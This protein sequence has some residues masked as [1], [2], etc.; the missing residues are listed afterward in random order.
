MSSREHF[1][2]ELSTLLTMAGAAIGLGNVWRFPYMMGSYGG[3][4][5]LLVFLF[6]TVFFAIPAV[7]GEWAL[8]RHTRHGPI[9][10]F[11]AALGPK[12]GRV[13]GYSLV[14]TVIIA[15][16]YYLVVIGNIFY[17]AYFAITQGFDSQSIPVFQQ[18]LSNGSLQYGV[19]C[20]LLLAAIFTVY[21]GLRNGIEV[22]SKLFVPFFFLTMLYLIFAA[23]QLP[24]ASEQMLVFLTP[25]FGQINSEVIFT[26]MG[27]AFF[28]M[29]LG[30]T[31]ILIYGSYMNASSSLPKQALFTAFSDTSAAL[32]AGM[33]IFPVCL[34]L[35]FKLDT[36]PNLIFVTMPALFE[37]MPGGQILG[38]FF[39]LA[40]SM[41]A[42]L[43]AIAALE[44]IVGGLSDSGDI[45]LSRKKIV[46]IIGIIE[47]L[48]MVGP[49][50]RPE[51][52]GTLDLIFGSG[53]QVLGSCLALIA[54]TFGFKKSIT[55]KQVFG[56]EKGL[57]PRIYF[58]WIHWVVPC[59]L[60]LVLISFIFDAIKGV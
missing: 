11:S 46:I 59:V 8:G 20:I 48:L 52:I 1:S 18:N 53:T 10:A 55:L 43:S 33:F 7:M 5:F 58:F 29:G 39:L 49:A 44:V 25:D 27:Q 26:A 45:P 13:I 2:S 31:Y 56:K 24:G 9:G 30:G 14:I 51:I 50:M 4:A 19:S 42:F 32:L 57:I 17:S 47:L 21:K 38:A 23:F 41:V 36:G 12:L 15:N 3:S 6:C 34:V 22:V 54:L 37:Q 60:L 28:S 40:L 16:S 35:G